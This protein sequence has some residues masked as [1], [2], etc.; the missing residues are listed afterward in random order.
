MGISDV[1]TLLGGLGLFLFGMKLLSDG[2]ELVAGS[3]LERLLKVLTSN[4][5]LAVI[6]G[7]VITAVIQSSSATTVMIVGFVNAGLMSLSQAVGV[8]MG[9][10]IGT[11]VT[12]VIVALN[13]KQIAPVAIFIGVVM[14]VFVKKKTIADIGQI[15]AGIGILFMGLNTMSSAMSPLREFQPFLDMM[16]EFS[17]NPLLG[18]L[19]GM[20]I[21]AVIQSSSASVAILQALAMQGLISIDAAV[22]ILF[23]QNIGTCVTALLSSIGTTK[24]AK[25]AAMIHLL[26]NVLGT[27]IFLALVF[28]GEVTPIPTFISIVKAA[29]DQV[30]VQISVAH[31]IFNVVTTALLFPL[32]PMLVRLS[33]KIVRGEDK[34]VGELKLEYIDDR[35]LATPSIAVAQTIQEVERMALLA[36]TNMHVAMEC[37]TDFSDAKMRE[38][39]EREKLINFLNHS[40]AAFLVKLSGIELLEKDAQTVGALFHIISDVERI[41]DH[42]EN[43][44]EDAQRSHDTK[45]RMSESAMSEL[46]E[47]FIM[48][49][50]L[51]DKAID[52]LKAQRADTEEIK[53]IA[54]SEDHIDMMSDK[55]ERNHIDRLTRK[56]CTPE[57]GMIFLHM[58]NNLERVADHSTNIAYAITGGDT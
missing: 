22:F 56:S 48:S 23:G 9:A 10:N 39:A 44:A 18:V 3:R 37:F 46:R 24:T 32:A 15:L 34:R 26:F 36:K 49:M 30:P 51:Y 16:V 41:G 27:V 12:S 8:I 11:T 33:K 25:R 45:S 5:F 29:S 4:R 54:D 55:L 20:L 28:I 14:L 42:A 47:L 58:I 13:P 53:V 50:S 43:I 40:I 35:I 2:L 6:V 19:A 7:F 52:V 21:T 17:H 1:L 31:I 57:T 38:V